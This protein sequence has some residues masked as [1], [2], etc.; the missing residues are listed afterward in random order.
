MEQSR[1]SM[2]RVDGPGVMLRSSSA[3]EPANAT[4]PPAMASAPSAT[5]SI[6]P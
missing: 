6:R 4:R 3:V 2:T 5:I 1:A